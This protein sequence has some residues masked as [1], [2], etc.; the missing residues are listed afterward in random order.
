MDP[1]VQLNHNLFARTAEISDV[2]ADAVQSNFSASVAWLRKYFLLA[3]CLL[4]L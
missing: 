2:V 3:V 4:L 1:A